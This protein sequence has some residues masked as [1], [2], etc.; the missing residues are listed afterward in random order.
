MHPKTIEINLVDVCNRSCSFCPRGASK[1]NTKKRLSIE[2][3]KI[4]GE[5]LK[6]YKN[7]ITICGMGEPLLHKHFKEVLSN[8][9]PKDSNNI[10]ITNGDYLTPEKSKDIK[11]LKI[12]N[13]RISLYDEDNS[14]YFNSFLSDFSVQYKHYYNKEPLVNR[15]EIYESPLDKNISRPCYLPFYKMFINYD[16][17]VYLCANDWSHSACMGDLRTQSL[18]EVWLSEEFYNYRKE[19]AE[20]QRSKFPCSSCTVDGTLHGKQYVKDLI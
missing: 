14:D 9:L 12:N 5:R 17:K 7:D 18:E 3:S 13:I 4:L 11:E 10:L 15:V 6:V 8:A 16:L 19:L 2:D 1:P 20:G